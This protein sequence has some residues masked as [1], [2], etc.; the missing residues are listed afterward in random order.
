[1]V[2]SILAILSMQEG[3]VPG[4]RNVPA[5]RSKHISRLDIVVKNRAQPVPAVLVCNYGFGGYYTALLFS[6]RNGTFTQ[7]ARNPDDRSAGP[8]R[9][10]PVL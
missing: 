2:G 10:R 7:P 6:R 4:T 1:V 5:T 3:I 8:G 9:P